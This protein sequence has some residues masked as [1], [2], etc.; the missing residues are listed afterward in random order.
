MSKPIYEL[1]IEP[2]LRMEMYYDDKEGGSLYFLVR[3][4]SENKRGAASKLRQKLKLAGYTQ[5]F[6]LWWE[7]CEPDA[8]KPGVFYHR[9]KFTVGALTSG[10]PD[11]AV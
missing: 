11:Q 2:Y 10:T 9:F 3:H 6:M 7:G 4:Y 1:Q 8:E 5:E